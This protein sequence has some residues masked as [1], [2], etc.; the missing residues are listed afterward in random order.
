MINIRS[1]DGVKLTSGGRV[2]IASNDG[3]GALTI[4]D[5]TL[6]DVGVYICIAENAFGKAESCASI[7]ISGKYKKDLVLL[8]TLSKTK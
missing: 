3:T 2:N 5:S 1:K 6:E 8:T 7:K 4:S